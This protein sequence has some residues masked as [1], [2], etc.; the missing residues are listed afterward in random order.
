[1]SVAAV[2]ALLGAAL[3]DGKWTILAPDSVASAGGST[4]TRQEDGSY[5]ASGT[6]PDKDA[7]TA[8]ART[9]LRGVTGFRLEA[10]T[11]PSLPAQGP[12]RVEH[13][14]FV[15]SEFKVQS[16]G[17]ALTVSRAAADFEQQDWPVANALDGKAETGWAVAPEFGKPHVAHFQLASPADGPFT[18]SLEFQSPHVRHVI[19]R[20]RISATTD[21]SRSAVS[22]VSPTTSR[23]SSTSLPR[24]APTPSARRSPSTT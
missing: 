7:F 9:E 14:N 16:S 19:G 8:V 11:D 4:L 1:V 23:R 10:L 2:L 15:L 22:A 18:F 5:L 20:F 6:N 3:Q 24:G 12:G 17:K 21:R 13:G